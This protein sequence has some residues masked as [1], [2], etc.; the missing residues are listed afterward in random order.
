MTAI[1]SKRLV[2]NI[3]ILCLVFQIYP[4]FAMKKSGV[5]KVEL[6][7]NKEEEAEAEEQEEQ[8]EKETRKRKN[9]SSKKRKKKEAELQENKEEE[10]EAEEQEEQ[11]EKG[12]RKRKNKSSQEKNR[13]KS[14]GKVIKTDG[15]PIHQTSEENETQKAEKEEL[16]NH[17]R[18]GHTTDAGLT[19]RKAGGR[20]R[21]VQ[22]IKQHLGPLDPSKGLEKREHKY[23]I[24]GTE[25]HKNIVAFI[26]IIFRQVKD[27][28]DWNE[29]IPQETE[30]EENPTDKKE[31]R[32]TEI[33]HIILEGHTYKV[34]YCYFPRNLQ[35]RFNILPATDIE[36]IENYTPTG[37]DGTRQTYGYRLLVV[38]NKYKDGKTDINSFFPYDEER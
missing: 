23:F 37:T 36:P 20:Q 14:I 3:I 30:D 4:T 33:G 26:D 12:I 34:S 38:H 9:K 18:I 19:Y 11:A 35:R 15:E 32:D 28:I 13:S 31:R 2:T 10:A 7:E 8:A 29:Q 21:K 17:I 16:S 24:E 27:K 1:F 22:H 6:Q 5:K 25:P